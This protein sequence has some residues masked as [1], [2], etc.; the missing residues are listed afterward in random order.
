MAKILI[1]ENCRQCHYFEENMYHGP[2]CWHD[3]I[4]KSVPDGKRPKKIKIFN[5]EEY[6]K[7]PIP[8]WCPLDNR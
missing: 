8:K 4:A 5:V 2:C 7:P 6:R 1:I 3:K